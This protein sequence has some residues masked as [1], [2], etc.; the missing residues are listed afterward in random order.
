MHILPF[1][2][3]KCKRHP[4]YSINVYKMYNCTNKIK[5]SLQIES[6]AC[7]NTTTRLI[8]IKL[9]ILHLTAHI[10]H[11]FYNYSYEAKK[12][13]LRALWVNCIVFDGPTGLH[14]RICIPNHMKKVILKQKEKTRTIKKKKKKGSFP[15]FN[16][17]C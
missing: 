14:Q 12:R 8:S 11:V 15:F 17:S 4:I 13:S 10:L 2:P 9:I 6:K 7:Q 5:A 16:L 1:L 3:K